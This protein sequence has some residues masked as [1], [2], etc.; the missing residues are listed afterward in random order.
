MSCQCENKKYGT[1]LDRYRRLGKAYAKMEECD[2]VIYLN[3][4]G[5]YG[6]C[7]VGEEKKPIVE[8]ISQY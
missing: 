4:D 5:T 3:D 1:E 6:I 8:F 2:V 7:R